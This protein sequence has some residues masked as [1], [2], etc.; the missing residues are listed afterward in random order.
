M[1]PQAPIYTFAQ[2]NFRC[3]KIIWEKNL[4]KKA[5]GIVLEK[6]K[7]RKGEKIKQRV[8]LNAELFI[9]LVYFCFQIGESC[10]LFISLQLIRETNL[11]LLFIVPLNPFCPSHNGNLSNLHSCFDPR[12]VFVP[13]LGRMLYLSKN[14]P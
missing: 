7:V 9:L 5:V 6:N 13:D 1:Y 14:R 12:N 4:R 3:V 2:L 11:C 10:F 8:R